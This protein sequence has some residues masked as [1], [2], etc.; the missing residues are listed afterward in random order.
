M[1]L[2]R[3]ASLVVL[4]ILS[5]IVAAYALVVYA[6]LPLGAAVDAGMRANFTA[7]R[8]GIYI[9]IFAAILT[10]VIGPLQFSARL[11]NKY[12]SLHRWS[13]RIYLGIGVL[14]GGSSGLYMASH[15]SGGLGARLG[16]TCL[17]LAWLY[18]GYRAYAAIRI[19]D[20]NAHQCWMTRN[21]ALT[22]A[23]VTLRLWLPASLALGIPLALAYPIIAWLS[24]VPNLLL[25][26]LLFN[27]PRAPFTRKE[28]I[29]H[30]GS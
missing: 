11:R 13:G 12:A 7:H 17:A 5:L 14:I 9:H 3:Q 29:G 27:R 26:E 20:I 4:L 23:A 10:L 30:P 24:W 22:F 15:A 25:A 8:T 28:F 16:F 19:R 18:T 2:M 21:F 1:N 6:F